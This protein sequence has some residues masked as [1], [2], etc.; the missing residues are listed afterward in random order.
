MRKICGFVFTIMLLISNSVFGQIGQTYSKVQKLYGEKNYPGL[1]LR[2]EG[3]L[4]VEDKTISSNEHRMFM[5]NSDSILIV[6]AIG[7]LDSSLTKAEAVSI[8][9]LEL[10]AFQQKKTVKMGAISYFWDTEHNYL[11]AMNSATS[12]STYPL[13]SLVL[14]IDPTLIEFHT[15]HITEWKLEEK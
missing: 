6:L 9:Q 11:I 1:E 8:I 7:H 12:N 2:K 13:T 15:S 3:N 4:L 14:I 5:Y 10:P